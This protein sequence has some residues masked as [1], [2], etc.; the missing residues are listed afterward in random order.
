MTRREELCHEVRN[1]L[2]AWAL[3]RRRL[4]DQ[5]VIEL[6]DRAFE[7]IEAALAKGLLD[8]ESDRDM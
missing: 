1:A 6:L 5:E 8:A 4:D 3:A 7:R 2:M